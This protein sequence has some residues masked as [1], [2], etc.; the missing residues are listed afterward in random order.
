M[1]MVARKVNLLGFA[2]HRDEGE[3]MLAAPGD[4]VVIQRGALRSV[5][6]RCPD[7]CGETLVVNLD[8]RVGKSWRLDMRTDK[9]T[10]YPSVWRDGG[11]GSHFIIWRGQLLW[12]DRFEEGNVEPNFDLVALGRRVLKSLRR[13]ELRSAEEI[14]ADL[15]EIT[16]E[17]SRAGQML[18]RRKLAICGSGRQRDWFALA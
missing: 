18:V 4:A 14:A 7:G 11:C 10:L 9:P 17:V 16:W 2:E 3:R 6:M 8:P 1:S 13:R 12:C 5:L 15:D